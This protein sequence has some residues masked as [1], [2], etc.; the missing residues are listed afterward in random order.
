MWVMVRPKKCNG[1]YGCFFLFVCFVFSEFGT[2]FDL[3]CRISKNSY[4][5]LIRTPPFS[6]KDANF[7]ILIYSYT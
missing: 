1:R 3:Y 6:G 2:S 4:T 5:L 7:R